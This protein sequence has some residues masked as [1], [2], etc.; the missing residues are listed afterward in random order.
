MDNP[1]RRVLAAQGQDFKGSKG[2]KPSRVQGLTL[3][4][5]S[6]HRAIV[7]VGI[8][9]P[10]GVELDLAIVEVEDRRV[11][12]LTIGIRIIITFVRLYSPN[13]KI[14]FLLAVRLY[15]FYFVFYLAVALQQT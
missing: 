3:R 11:V 1:L 4:D 2:F 5:E 10:V 14:Y 6:R 13:I 8:V 7:V 12:E 15:S 9:D